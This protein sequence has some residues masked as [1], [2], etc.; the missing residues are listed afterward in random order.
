MIATQTDIRT[1]T[2]RLATDAFEAFCADI[3]AMFGIGI[4]C[5][6]KEQ[7][8][9]NADSLQKHFKKLCAVNTVKA[10]GAVNG[11]FY[12]LLGQEALFTMAGIFVMLPEKKILE[13]RKFGTESQAQ[14]MSDAI[15]EA[16][17]LLVGTWDRVFRENVPS[18][19]HFL[20][21]GTFIGNPWQNTE[22]HIGLAKDAVLN[23]CFYELTA[24]EFP[25]F[26]CCVVFPESVFVPEPEAT[27]EEKTQEPESAAVKEVV[28]NNAVENSQKQPQ[29]PL[30]S[31][32]AGSE[33]VKIFQ[34][35]DLK[36]L[37]IM[38]SD[39]KWCDPGCTVEKAMEQM[40]QTRAD[41]LL[42][43]SEQKAQGVVAMSDLSAALSI[44][45]RPMFAKW[46]RELDEATLRI[47]VQAIM[48]RPVRCILPD[49]PLDV[50]AEKIVRLGGCLVVMDINGKT[51]GI[52]TSKDFL[53][54]F[55]R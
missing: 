43:G 12:L 35:L 11:S 49:T 9:G 22:K 29:Q 36:A 5:Q 47:R 46:K 2:L 20:Q 24:G 10:Q 45:L 3:E 19:K 44:Y 21:T 15:K 1:E 51:L 31:V 53:T 55:L 16:G 28:Q 41:Y 40:Q 7:Q 37:D 17:N 34:I 27:T 8:S 23:A 38:N 6:T 48:S 39:I 14:A 33:N 52:V 30:A 4:K 26:E 42:V 32:S 50:V 18:H 54:R 25:P 13:S